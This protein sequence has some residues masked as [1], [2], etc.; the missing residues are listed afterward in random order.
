[1]KVFVTV[2]SQMLGIFGTALCVKLKRRQVKE[3]NS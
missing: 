1:M 3:M 2:P